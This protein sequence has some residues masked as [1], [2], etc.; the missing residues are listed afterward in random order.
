MTV[1]EKLRALYE[2]Q[3]IDS[4]LDEIR[5]LKGEL[6]ME[7]RDLEDDIAGTQTRMKKLEAEIKELDLQISRHK[8][9]I[10]DSENL[11]A[12]Y[13]Q[14]Q[15]N[16]KNNREFEALGREIENQKLEIQLSQKKML[17]IQR[18]IKAREEAVEQNK[19]LIEGKNRELE[20]KNQE[21]KDIIEKTEKQ[22]AELQKK[23]ERAAKHI[24][25]RLL[26]GYQKIRGAYRN[27]LAVACIE[28][29]A[30]GGCFNQIPPQR[31]LEIRQRKK[32]IV[33]EHCGRVLVDDEI[34]TPLM[35][36][37]A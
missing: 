26:V 27:G 15:N 29:N 9:N 33:C 1:E 28:R 20:L 35:A 5:I 32:V 16:V 10:K 3:K 12:R 37:D 30:C 22:E 11:I 7:V 34:A 36:A 31:Q 18:T 19:E 6:P 23:S 25:E 14:Q 24:E 21:L 17:D 8:V 4:Q 2:L 13:I